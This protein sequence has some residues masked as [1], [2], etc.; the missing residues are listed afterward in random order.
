MDTIFKYF[1]H[2]LSSCEHLSLVSYHLQILRAF[3]FCQPFETW[4]MIHQLCKIDF[5]NRPFIKW[6]FWDIEVELILNKIGKCL[7]VFLS[8]F[9]KGSILVIDDSG[10]SDSM[11]G[12]TGIMPS[13]H[14]PQVTV[15]E[16]EPDA[17]PRRRP[18]LQ[19]G[20]SRNK[21]DPKILPVSKCFERN[22]F[23]LVPRNRLNM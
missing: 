14:I 3:N 21:S 5:K 10:A 20:I 4:N 7:L 23:L 1:S 8:G 2:F 16:P 19:R 22:C 17:K 6:N 13:N 18:P 9:D 12:T 11:N 15:E